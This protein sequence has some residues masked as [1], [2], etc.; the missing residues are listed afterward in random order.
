ME[1][2]VLQAVVEMRF[3]CGRSL[4]EQQLEQQLE[5]MV[6]AWRVAEASQLAVVSAPLAAMLVAS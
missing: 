5:Q 4:L 1:S 3:V 2:G 6:V